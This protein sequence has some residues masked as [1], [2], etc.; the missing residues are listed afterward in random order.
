MPPSERT[1][2]AND[3]RP[4]ERAGDAA[5]GAGGGASKREA[6]RLAAAPL[7]LCLA[8]LASA[9]A[10]ELFAASLWYRLTDAAGPVGRRAHLAPAAAA[11]CHLSRLAGC[12]AAARR[13]SRPGRAPA[14]GGPRRRA[15]RPPGRPS[16]PSGPS[17]ASSRPRPPPP[18]PSA[19]EPRPPAPAPAPSPPP[20]GPP[21]RAA[22]R[23]PPAAAGG[24]R[25]GGRPR[26]P[27]PRGA[28]DKLPLPLRGPPLP[29][30]PPPPP[31]P[32]PSRPPFTR[33]CDWRPPARPRPHAP[34]RPA[35]AS[36]AP[37]PRGRPAR[38]AGGCRGGY[39]ADRVTEDF[40]GFRGLVLG[41]VHALAAA[42]A[43]S[44][45][46]L[47]AFLGHPSPALSAGLAAGGTRRPPW[48]A[49]PRLAA[50]PL[51]CG[52]AAAGALLPLA[53]SLDPGL[54]PLLAPL[55]QAAGA[56]AGPALARAALRRCSIPG[57]FLAASAACALSCALLRP[58]RPRRN[59]KLRTD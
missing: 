31:S 46:L 20:A 59:P 11:L 24:P 15:S 12:A 21:P 58:P 50:P 39:V 5:P 45:A 1:S 23:A 34:R 17:S 7:A 32:S 2:A 43:A 29:A 48:R 9:A 55:A 38:A 13:L 30:A 41:G 22:R 28:L 47:A 14:R 51:L 16:S 8:A 35:N 37:P 18:P 42:A 3:E 26:R 10:P 33:S 49:A 36:L 53:L 19:P 52:W 56:A 27:G 40:W 54:P 4:A 57:L 25:G 44:T 6:P